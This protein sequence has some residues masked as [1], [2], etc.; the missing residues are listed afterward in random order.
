MRFG[1]RPSGFPFRV[2]AAA[3]AGLLYAKALRFHTGTET[4]R[5]NWDGTQSKQRRTNQSKQPKSGG[6]AATD[7]ASCVAGHKIRSSELLRR[8]GAALTKS[9]GRKTQVPF[10]PQHRERL[11]LTAIGLSQT[12]C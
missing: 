7:W 11:H 10:P 4:T 1:T 5:L 12:H 2:A 3:A 9:A 8:L 6:G